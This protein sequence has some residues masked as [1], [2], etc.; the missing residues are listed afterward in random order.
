MWR[1]H[2]KTLKTKMMVIEIEERLPGIID[3]WYMRQGLPTPIW[4]QKKPYFDE[5]GNIVRPE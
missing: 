1:T 3:E 2:M 4:M 5:D